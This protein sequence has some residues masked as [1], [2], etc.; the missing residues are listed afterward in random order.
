MD[1]SCCGDHSLLASSLVFAQGAFSILVCMP[2]SV[3]CPFASGSS[4]HFDHKLS[5]SLNNAVAWS[6]CRT[7]LL[8]GSEERRLAWGRWLTLMR[9]TLGQTTCAA[10]ALLSSTTCT[11]HT[12]SLMRS[13]KSMTDQPGFS[14]VP[15]AHHALTSLNKWTAGVTTRHY[16]VVLCSICQTATSVLLCLVTGAFAR[17]F[18]TLRALSA[19][20][21][22][23]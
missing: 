14:V 22:H 11:A 2:H 19:C 4:L 12:A 16:Y 9:F 17:P 5:A 7:C 13:H 1:R 23:S 8:A 20:K 10:G 3:C 15:Y 6:R 21:D 18:N